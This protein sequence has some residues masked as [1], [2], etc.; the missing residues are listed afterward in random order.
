MTLSATPTLIRFN[1]V[2]NSKKS[3]P[4]PKNFDPG[5]RER[6]REK[7]EIDQGVS[8]ERETSHVDLMSDCEAVSATPEL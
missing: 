5:E 6:A 8:S 2:S 3:A 1:T 4:F 7:E